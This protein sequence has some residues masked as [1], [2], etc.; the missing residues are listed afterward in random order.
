[1]KAFKELD[2]SR[3]NAVAGMI[4]KCASVARRFDYCQQ[5]EESNSCEV[6]SSSNDKDKDG[7]E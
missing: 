3:Q 5:E 1:M 6:E 4:E 7:K 2:I